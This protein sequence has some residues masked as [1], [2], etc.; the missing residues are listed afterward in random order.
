MPA[1]LLKGCEAKVYASGLC[2]KH[3]QRLRTTGSL[4]EGPRAHAPPE[5]RFWRRIAK[6]GPDECWVNPNQKGGRYSWFQVGG[7]GSPGILGH[8]YAYEITKGPIPP[9]MLVMHSCDNPR[10]V[11][12]NHLSLGTPKDNTQDML[13]KGRS[14]HITPKGVEHFRAV[15]TPELVREIRASKETHGGLARRLGVSPNT[16]RAVRIGRTWAHVK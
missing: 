3:Y 14:P 1:C 6:L 16:V 4:Q 11:N 10:C 12:P 2:S 9:G 15:L 5:V 13:R 7:K 8:R